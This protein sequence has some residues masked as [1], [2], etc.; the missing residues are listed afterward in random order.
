MCGI[1]GVSTPRGVNEKLFLEAYKH[2][3]HRGPDYKSH[4]ISHNREV[5]FGHTRLSIID[6]SDKASQPMISIS[7]EIIIT[8]NGEIYNYRELR[9][10]IINSSK[11]SK[12]NEFRTTSDTEVLLNHIEIYGIHETISSI[13]GMYAISIYN[14]KERKIYL[15]RDYAGEKPIYYQLNKKN[16]FIFASDIN[17]IKI[18][19]NDQKISQLNI[20]TYLDFGFLPNEMTIYENIK[21]LEPNCLLTY[22]LKSTKLKIDNQIKKPIKQYEKFDNKNLH[23]SLINLLRKKLDNYANTDVPFGVFLSGGIDSSLVASILKKDLNKNF[24]TF[25]VVFKNNILSEEENIKFI[26]RKLGLKYNLFNLEKNDLIDVV[27]KIKYAYTEPFADSS[28]IPTMFLANQSK[29]SISVAIGGDGA[30]ELFGGYR[31]H[32]AFNYLNKIPFKKEFISYF[33]ELIRKLLT[34]KNFRNKNSVLL[35]NLTY[36]SYLNNDILKYYLDILTSGNSLKYTH[37]IKKEFKNSDVESLMDLDFNFYL[38]NSVLTKL[39]RATMYYGVE[40]RSPFL[41]DKIISFSKNINKDLNFKSFRG[42]NIL[43]NALKIYLGDVITKSKKKGFEPPLLNWLKNDLKE[44]AMDNYLMAISKGFLEK[45]LAKDKIINDFYSHKNFNA[46]Y[47][48]RI[49]VL[50]DWLNHNNG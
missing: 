41:D 22:D 49:A 33:F 9:K 13:E 43:R 36:L 12:K 19:N 30:D 40:S 8:F 16:E 44:W 48:W 23:L 28:Q 2:L 46:N 32:I 5:G 21:K 3:S 34:I 6:L 17:A 7:N 4:W 45:S 11:F 39:D 18:Y 38:P 50:S 25:S 26:N 27:N 20:D 24:E 42:K 47:V 14:V 1:F 15:I 10:K 29:K 35:N 37:L 31:R